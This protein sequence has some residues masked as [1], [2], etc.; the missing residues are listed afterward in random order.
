MFDRSGG[1]DAVAF[2]VVRGCAAHVYSPRP[3][4]G[5]GLTSTYSSVAENQDAW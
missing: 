3:V 5:A 4:W 2:R 1:S